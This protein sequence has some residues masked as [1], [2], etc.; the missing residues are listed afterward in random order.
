MYFNLTILEPDSDLSRF[1]AETGEEAC[2]G[3]AAELWP[4]CLAL[5]WHLSPCPFYLLIFDRGLETL[6]VL[7]EEEGSSKTLARKNLKSCLNLFCNNRSLQVIIYSSCQSCKGIILSLSSNFVSD[8]A[9][10]VSLFKLCYTLGENVHLQ[11][12]LLPPILPWLQCHHSHYHLS[13]L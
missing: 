13:F 6:K 7:K 1:L 9:E 5:L 4:F 3:C 10:N 8:E 11:L 2:V 12:L